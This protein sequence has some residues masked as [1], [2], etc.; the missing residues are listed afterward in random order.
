MRED[1]KIKI[2]RN[3]R[4]TGG[5]PEVGKWYKVTDVH[6]SPKFSRRE[7]IDKNVYFIVVDGIRTRVHGTHCETN[8]YDYPTN[9]KEFFEKFRQQQEEKEVKKNEET[10]NAERCGS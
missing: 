9:T 7:G 8:G 1:L 10:E 6:Q 5:V 2:L 3:D 4:C